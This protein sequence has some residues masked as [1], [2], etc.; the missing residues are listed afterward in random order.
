MTIQLPSNNNPI[1]NTSFYL[2][3][4]AVLST[5][6]FM[7]SAMAAGSSTD[8]SSIQSISTNAT[9]KPSAVAPKIQSITPTPTT[10]CPLNSGGPSLLGTTWLV[11]TLYGNRVAHPLKMDMRVSTH[12]LSGKAGCNKYSA[13]FNRVGYT[14]FKVRNIVQTKKKCKVL[15]PYKTA[16]S[17]DVGRIEGSYLRILRRMG[18]VRQMPSG[19]LFFFDRNGKVGLVLRKIA[20]ENKRTQAAPAP[21]PK[22]VVA[23]KA[24]QQKVVIKKAIPAPTTTAPQQKAAPQKIEE[25]QPIIRKINSSD[26]D[27]ISNFFKKTEF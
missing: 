24:T 22:K 14:G 11:E 10:A 16:K 8:I 27:L 13:T 5:S 9:A 1:I 18:S 6:L 12:A 3:P 23:P 26:E 4:I 2:L 21:V 20:D 15:I 7:V 25:Q 17:I 19:K